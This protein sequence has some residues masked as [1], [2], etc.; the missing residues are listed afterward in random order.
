M[1]VGPGLKIDIGCGTTAEK[2]YL[3]QDV[4]PSI[5]GLDL[6][7]QIEDLEQYIAPASCLTIRA[8]HVMEHFPAKAIPGLFQMIY[9]LLENEGIFEIIV[10]SF[11]YHA[12]LVDEG[13]DEKAI[14]Y[15]FGGQLNEW[16]FHKT[17]FTPKTLQKQLEDAGFTVNVLIADTSLT[18]YAQKNI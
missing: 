4:D 17:G 15:A 13:E 8:S 3:R 16:D 5:P 12:Q 7:C 2:D 14:H 6:V 11:T 9:N 1:L 18:A 10:P